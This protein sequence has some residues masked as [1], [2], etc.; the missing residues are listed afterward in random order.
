MEINGAA[1]FISVIYEYA[2]KVAD[3]W[4]QHT[5]RW[6]DSA[7]F[8]LQNHSLAYLAL[9][10]A[11]LIFFEVAIAISRLGNNL[12]SRCNGDYEGLQGGEGY[13]YSLGLGGL[14]AATLGVSNWVF[15]KMLRIPLA[16]WQVTAVSV[17]TCFFYLCYKSG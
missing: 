5:V 7:S 17:A 8:Y 6:L 13:A 15:C 11:N 16:G 9:I 2:W 10:G 3:Q 1:D 14:F 12:F 4:A